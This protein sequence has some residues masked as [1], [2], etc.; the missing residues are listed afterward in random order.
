MSGT[1][2]HYIPQCHQRWWDKEAPR[3]RPIVTRVS[4]TR[5]I[6]TLPSKEVAEDDHFYSTKR[7]DGSWDASV[8]NSITEYENTVGPMLNAFRSCAAGSVDAAKSAA[9]VSHMCFRNP[10][11][12]KFLTDAVTKSIE[13]FVSK[14]EKPGFLGEY[15][16]LSGSRPKGHLRS[17]LVESYQKNRA[18][19]KAKGLSQSKFLDMAWKLAKAN[20][21][22]NKPVLSDSD[23]SKL[24]ALAGEMPGRARDTHNSAIAEAGAVPPAWAVA[25]SQFHWTMVDCEGLNLLLPDCVAVSYDSVAGERSFM[26]SFS[27]GEEHLNVYFPIT[28]EKM[29]VGSRQAPQ[30]SVPA[31]INDVLA[32]C[33]S[34]FFIAREAT[35]EVKLLLPKIGRVVD[36]FIDGKISNILDF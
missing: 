34:D 9:L 6:Q 8:D 15:A 7:T 33:S 26:V 36:G 13:G 12:R 18:A 14:I 30:P 35:R 19:L 17:Q 24:S 3:K 27:E 25:F 11:P 16:G 1:S 23:Q 4:R 2:Q 31:E 28:P 20:Y 21:D 32:S 22:P 5:G 10:L 29:L